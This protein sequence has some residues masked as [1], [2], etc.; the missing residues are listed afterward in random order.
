MRI[1]EK[2]MSC[3]QINVAV[4]YFSNASEPE[5]ALTHWQRKECGRTARISQIGTFN[6]YILYVHICI[7]YVL[8]SETQGRRQLSEISNRSASDC[9][10]MGRILLRSVQ[11]WALWRWCSSGLQYAPNNASDIHT[12]RLKFQLH[13][14]RESLPELIIFNQNLF[15]QAK[16]PCLMF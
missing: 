7:L 4:K 16:R 1:S 15:E 5:S 10:Q 11:S 14:K 13:F 3:W 12:R 8:T 6:L 9:Q 2:N